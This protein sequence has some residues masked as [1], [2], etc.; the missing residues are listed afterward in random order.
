MSK[1]FFK[2]ADG[3][4]IVFDV[5]DVESFYALPMWFEH[6]FTH[7]TPDIPMILVGKKIDYEYKVN[8]EKVQEFAKSMG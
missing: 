3:V 4:I 5:S 6:I 1:T 8:E 2:K 7:S